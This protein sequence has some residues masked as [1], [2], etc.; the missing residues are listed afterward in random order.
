MHYVLFTYFIE[1]TFCKVALKLFYWFLRK[2]GPK[3]KRSFW[4]EKVMLSFILYE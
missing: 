4:F 1:I 2:S 3:A